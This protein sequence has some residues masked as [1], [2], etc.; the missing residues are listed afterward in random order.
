MLTSPVFDFTEAYEALV[1]D[2][3]TET[4]HYGVSFD[5]IAAQWKLVDDIL[6]QSPIH[7]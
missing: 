6:T 3:I 7:V 1:R 5:E 4:L 2:V